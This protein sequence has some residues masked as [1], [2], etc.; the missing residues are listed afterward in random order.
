MPFPAQGARIAL[1]ESGQGFHLDRITRF[2]KLVAFNRRGA[3]ENV[4]AAVHQK[5]F[6]AAP[7]AGIGHVLE[8]IVKVQDH[9]DLDAIRGVLAHGA[10]QERYRT[11]VRV[12]VEARLGDGKRMPPPHSAGRRTHLTTP[13]GFSARTGHVGSHFGGRCQP[14]AIVVDGHDAFPALKFLKDVQPSCHCVRLAFHEF[15]V[16]ADPFLGLGQAHVN[17]VGE[18]LQF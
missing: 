3:D 2:P 18:A 14:L 5:G 4:P 1:L 9:L 11:I 16:Q 7:P 10:R 12:R 17:V 15:Q 13:T 6:L 8:K